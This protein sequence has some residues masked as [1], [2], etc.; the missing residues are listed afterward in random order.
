M[1]VPECLIMRTSLYI[2]ITFVVADLQDEASIV[3]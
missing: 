3:N 2:L 1:S